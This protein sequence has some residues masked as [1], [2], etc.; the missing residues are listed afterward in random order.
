M[1]RQW[2]L[3]STPEKKLHFSS[4][5]SH[6]TVGM[7]FFKE[8]QLSTN[9]HNTEQNPCSSI[10]IFVVKEF[11][12]DSSNNVACSNDEWLTKGARLAC[13]LY[14][15]IYLVSHFL[16]QLALGSKDEH[17]HW[18]SKAHAES[19]REKQLLPWYVLWLCWAAQAWCA[20]CSLVRA[21]SELLSVLDTGGGEL[22]CKGRTGGSEPCFLQG[23]VI[24][25][26]TAPLQ[27]SFQVSLFPCITRFPS[28]TSTD[29]H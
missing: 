23:N 17:L 28:G 29:C 24:S 13:S 19:S 2:K 16:Q 11:I 21:V 14:L 12:M 7:F 9:D 25:F 18:T 22:G 6:S 5:C 15:F 27:G 1:L 4:K 8:M 26:T 20:G 3:T 10:I